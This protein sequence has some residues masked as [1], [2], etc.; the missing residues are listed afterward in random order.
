MF[1]QEELIP[2]RQMDGAYL[3]DRSPEYFTPLLNYLR[4]GQLILDANVNPKGVLEEAQFYGIT[5][6]IPQIMKLISDYNQRV[7]SKIEEPL[8]RLSI[9]KALIVTSSC[10][11]L[12]FQGVDLTDVDLSQLELRNINFKYAKMRRCNLFQANLSYCCFDRADLTG[13]LLDSA[14]LA[15]VKMQRCIL[16]GASLKR[17]NFVDPLSSKPLRAHL[18]GV[19]LR[20]ANLEEANLDGAN[21]RVSI[22]KDAN[23]QNCYLRGTDFAG[24]NL[25]RCDFSG[26]DLKNANL[27]GAYM[28][29]AVFDFVITPLH[30]S[31]TIGQ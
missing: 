4:H 30:M 11:E 13:A 18:E 25:E 15:G 17:A 2:S 20:G 3:I 7:S 31:Q 5:S 28:A 29:D 24:A 1:L 26:S 9:I 16:E 23:L 8:T 22:L 19:N 21:L 14:N 27:R 12:R 10:S 6:A